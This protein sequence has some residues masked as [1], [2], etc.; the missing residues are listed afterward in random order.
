MKS[1]AMGLDRRPGRERV[2][3]DGLMAEYVK[4]ESQPIVIELER[5][6]K[7]DKKYDRILSQYKYYALYAIWYVAKDLSIINAI[8]SAAKR[9][10]FPLSRLWLSLEDQLFTQKDQ[11]VLPRKSGHAV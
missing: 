8:L 10:S 9:N 2:I 7:S 1:Q 6:R 4:G 5:T 3:P 11:V